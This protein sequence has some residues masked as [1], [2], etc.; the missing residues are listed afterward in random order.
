MKDNKAK[1][2]GKA[3]VFENAKDL[4]QDPNIKAILESLAVINYL[5]QNGVEVKPSLISKIIKFIT[6]G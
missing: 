1:V 4:S 5:Q 6:R 2:F 3:I